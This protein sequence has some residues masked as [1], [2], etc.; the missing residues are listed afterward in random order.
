MFDATVKPKLFSGG[1]GAVSTAA[2]Y[3]LFCQMLLHGGELGKTR[4]L[5]PSTIHLM[6]SNAL[7]PGIEY[8]PSVTGQNDVGPT[9][10]MGQGFG[11]GFAVRTEAG[12]NPLPGSVGSFYWTGASG[13]TFFVDPKQELILIM[14]VQTPFPTNRFYRQV[15]RYLAYQA[16]SAPN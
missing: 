5:S 13:T 3:L 6:T 8:A 16:L 15:F 11:L 12:G 2:D 9:P 7:K 4:L 1:G 10:A 14:M